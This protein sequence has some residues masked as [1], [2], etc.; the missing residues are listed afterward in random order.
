[1]SEI[2]PERFEISGTEAVKS[3][4]PGLGWPVYERYEIVE[5]DGEPWVVAPV[6][7]ASFME[8]LEGGSLRD[9][10]RIERYR[11]R[12]PIDDAKRVYPPLKHP[13]LVVDLAHLADGPITP[14]AVLRWA[15]IYGLL[16]FPEDD[17]VGTKGG[18]PAFRVEGMGRKESVARFAKAAGE[19]RTWLR[20]YEAITT[21]DRDIELQ[22][23]SS[24][25]GLLPPDVLRPWERREVPERPWL[26]G[27]L[28]RWT[29][30]NLREYCYLQ[31][32]TY[33]RGGVPTGRFTDTTGYK[34]LIGAIW[35]QMLRLL[36]AEGERVRH[37]KLPDCLRV[38]HFEPGQPP[39]E[40][41]SKKN[42]RGKYK[43]RAD[44]Q[45]CKDRPC[46]QKYHYRKRAGWAG[47]S[48]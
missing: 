3:E 42:A 47:Y 20:A 34:S 40:P 19:V 38:I 35:V 37:C 8:P 29:E 24:T 33:T 17:V 16:G 23:L 10:R 45:F 25:M 5:E 2:T 27:V 46:K 21:T 30:K 43:T 28:G 4:L 32:I 31:V 6:S 41:G 44:R 9:G 18:F 15:H 1:M 7:S 14:E 36:E 39:A 26:Y 13:N 22:E 48:S 11:G 12:D